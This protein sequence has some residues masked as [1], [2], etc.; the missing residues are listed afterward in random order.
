MRVLL[1]DIDTLRPDHMGCYGY[2]RN[3]TPCMDKIAEEGV[4]FSN[5]YTPNAPCLPSRA[6]LASGRYGIHT[7]VIGHGGTCGD[8]RLIGEDRNFK[9]LN[10]Q[11]S[12]FNVFRKAG[13]YTVS[14]STFAERHSAW[15]FN[16]G[17]NE[18]YNYGKSGNE[19]ADEVTPTALKWI[20]EHADKDNWFMHYHIWDPH[21]PY[22]TPESYG[23]PFKDEPL[24]DNWVTEEVFK[25]HRNTIGA[26]TA[27][28]MDGYKDNQ[29]H[30]YPRYSDGSLKDLNDVKHLIDG[31][32]CGIRFSDDNI[33]KIV[34]LLKSKDIY[35]DT[36]IIITADHGENLGELG[37]YAEHATAD[38]PC[39]KI[40][41]IIKWPGMAKGY[42]DN[43]LHMN[44]DLA[45]TVAELLDVKPYDKWDGKSYAKVL[46]SK[47]DCSYEYAVIN[48]C[49]HVCQR[50]V[51]FGD[52]L[53]I[54]TIHGGYHLFDDEMLFNI[55][56]DP[57][58]TRNIINEE[59]SVADKGARLILDWTYEM[60]KCSDSDT[61]PLWTVMREGGPLH[62]RGSL[63]SYVE[64]LR[65]T[66][67][68]DLADKLLEKYKDDTKSLK[69]YKIKR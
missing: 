52:Y 35:E 56:E 61:D 12:L 13:Y 7:G 55:K 8:M 1:I 45:P 41:M 3:T 5:Y 51:R 43:G 68:S 54:R 17:F 46:T 19:T 15:W 66:G 28:E 64:R 16:A 69:Y 14:I 40:P 24:P 32:D 10:S 34:D 50:S 6:A 22:R 29:D 37:I 25:E 63:K 49:A 59:R 18:T 31:Y 39:C 48:Q 21:T 36:A 27:M 38:E 9:D 11:N 23:D 20:S 47:E 42:K 58:E 2:K 33:A 30:T 53:Y 62:A 57:H 44:I 67:R 4:M 26:H 60:M 65:E